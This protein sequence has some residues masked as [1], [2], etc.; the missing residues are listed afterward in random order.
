MSYQIVKGI[1]KVI[2]PGGKN[3]VGIADGGGMFAWIPT[4]E[5]IDSYPGEWV[6]WQTTIFRVNAEAKIKWREEQRWDDFKDDYPLK[7]ISIPEPI[8]QQFL[9]QPQTPTQNA[10]QPRKNELPPIQ[11][12]TQLPPIQSPIP[13]PTV[14]MKISYEN[15]MIIYELREIKELLRG[16]KQAIG[17]MVIDEL[18]EEALS[19]IPMEESS[20]NRE[21]IVTEEIVEDSFDKSDLQ[22]KEESIQKGNKRELPKVF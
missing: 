8:P 3:I 16:L 20:P 4:E 7:V 1:V 5:I 19:D 17:L 2:R 12:T 22:L 13:K 18:K 10:Q 11:G 9:V 14:D 15:Q 6:N 21:L